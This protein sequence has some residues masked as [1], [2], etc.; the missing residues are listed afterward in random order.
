MEHVSPKEVVFVF[1]YSPR[2]VSK[3]AKLDWMGR[4]SPLSHFFSVQKR[5][6]FSAL[7]FSFFEKKYTQF[8]IAEI[9]F[10]NPV[11]KLSQV[12]SL[13]LQWML[14]NFSQKKAKVLNKQI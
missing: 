14:K 4:G 2:V 1:R 7:K 10:Q 11:F 12:N 5:Q 8:A 3:I 6:S 9:E 13:T